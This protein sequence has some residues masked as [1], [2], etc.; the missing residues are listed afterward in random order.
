MKQTV[1]IVFFCMFVLWQLSVTSCTKSHPEPGIPPY[2]GDVVEWEM[3]RENPASKALI[4]GNGVGSFEEGDTIVVYAR[5]MAD[6]RVKHVT[7]KLQ[8]G[9]WT[10][11]VRWEELGEEVLF[12]AWYT[13]NAVGLHQAAQTTSEYRHTLAV[14]QQGEGYGSADLL[15]AQ[16]RGKKAKKCN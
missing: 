6:G 15:C 11:K 5:N 16:T 12:T 3:V 4:N 14:S 2:E 9:R 8:N 1:R 7:L 13:K 10:P